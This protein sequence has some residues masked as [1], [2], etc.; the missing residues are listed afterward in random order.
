MFEHEFPFKSNDTEVRRRVDLFLLT[1]FL[2]VTIAMGAV[3]SSCDAKTPASVSS[4][5]T[6]NVRHGEIA[7]ELGNLLSELTESHRLMGNVLVAQGDEVIFEKSYGRAEVDPPR[8]NSPALK[9]RIGSV[10]K[11]L[12]AIGVMQLKERGILNIDDPII[13]YLPDYPPGSG[14]KI[15][16]RHLLNHTSGLPDYIHA[17][18]AEPYLAKSSSPWELIALFEYLP[19]ESEPGTVFRYNN[20]GYLLL[21]HIIETVSGMSYSEFLD[22][23]IFSPAGMADSGLVEWFSLPR[24]GR[25]IG[26]TYPP[27]TQWLEADSSTPLVEDIKIDASFL[28]AAGGVYATVP[29]MLKLTRALLP[30]AL[31]KADSL[32]EMTS[33]QASGESFGSELNYGFGWFVEA[34]G[35]RPEVWHIGGAPGFNSLFA[36][37]P[38]DDVCVIVLLN[39]S[40]G[41]NNMRDLSRRIEEILFPS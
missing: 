41:F 19:L 15:T 21:G 5:E 13:N 32:R 4:V 6:S 40:I 34:D 23:N 38:K 29:D 37:Y 11:Q 24:K 39:V 25:A 27:E 31:L 22:R 7:P 33:V 26:Y 12:T 18:A 14:S 30:G 9:F 16:I 3:C 2:S 28:N 36:R 20:S 1:I 17:Q 8:D 10:T 35:D